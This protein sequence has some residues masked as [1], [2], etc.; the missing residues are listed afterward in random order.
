MYSI[1][2]ERMDGSMQSSIRI[3]PSW[4]RGTYIENG[5]DNSIEHAK[6]LEIRRVDG[7]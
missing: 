4:I 7:V 5:S 1:P 2:F 3:G 6:G